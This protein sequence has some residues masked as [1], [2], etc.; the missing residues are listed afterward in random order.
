MMTE[1][2]DYR[3]RH[4][5]RLL[6]AAAIVIL[7]VGTFGAGVLDQARAAAAGTDALAV[8]GNFIAL[9]LSINSEYGVMIEDPTQLADLIEAIFAAS[10]DVVGARI[11]DAKGTILARRGETTE[12]KDVAVFRA[13]VLSSMAKDTTTTIGAVEVALQRRSLA[14]RQQMDLFGVYA[15]RVTAMNAEYGVETANPLQLDDLA[16]AAMVASRAAI[17]GVAFY[18]AKGQVL[19]QNGDPVR[20]VPADPLPTTPITEREDSILYRAPI[21]GHNGDP[22]SGTIGT[23]YVSVAKGPFGR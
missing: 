2:L 10:P 19:S 8:R 3:T 16:L 18:D 21:V 4:P 13:P 9:N 6:L 7:T 22:Q 17:T 11:K 23:V 5:H 1:T 15:A 20:Q 14:P 12:G